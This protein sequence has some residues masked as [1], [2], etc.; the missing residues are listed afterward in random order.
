MGGGGLRGRGWGYIGPQAPAHKR[1]HK[2]HQ[3]CIDF[4]VGAR[5]RGRPLHKSQRGVS[6]RFPRWRGCPPLRPEGQSP[7]TQTRGTRI[8]HFGCRTHSQVTLTYKALAHNSRMV[9]EFSAK[10]KSCRASMRSLSVGFL[11]SLS[12]RCQPVLRSENARV[13]RWQ[14]CPPLRPEGQS[15]RVQTRGTRI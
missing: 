15:I 3:L 8:Y 6:P 10:A 2:R 5:T 7:R 12:A 11:A 4:I 1:H 13:P 14:G 9:W